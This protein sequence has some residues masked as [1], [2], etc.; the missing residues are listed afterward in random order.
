M[1]IIVA[2]CKNGIGL[3]NRLPWKLKKDMLFF[4]EKTIGKGN[5]A[6]LMGNNTWKSLKEP[7][8]NRDNLVLSRSV[9]ATS[10]HPT[11]PK[12]NHIYF[13][14][15]SAFDS[16]VLKKK[17]D[18]VWI[19]GGGEIYKQFV[20]MADRIY[21]TKIYGDFECD[22]FFPEIPPKFKLLQSSSIYIENGILYKFE[23]YKS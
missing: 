12:P 7:L 5:N 11:S 3:N 17:Y 6:V 14:S 2:S 9:P 21:L 19:I 15:Y 4:K 16:Y 8:S 23:V 20:H 22:V 10:I 18:N 1:N 13:N